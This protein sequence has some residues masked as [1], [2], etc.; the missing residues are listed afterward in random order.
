M[1]SIFGHSP[2]HVALGAVVFMVLT[3]LMVACGEQQPTPTSTPTATPTSTPGPTATPTALP[4]A[5]PTSLPTRTPL[6]TATPTPTP[7]PSPTATPV[8]FFLEVS[9]PQDQSII[10]TSSVQVQGQTV[11]DAVVSVNSQVVTV[12]P[13][14]SFAT[15]VTLIEGPNSIEVIA[16]DFHGHQASQ[17][18]SVI[19]S[20]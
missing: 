19:Y 14:G 6:P 4:T 15:A 2:R 3:G 5:T 7:V 16:S 11:P 8:A 12:D 1:R 13:D 17:V 20:P 18:L 10:R 9:A